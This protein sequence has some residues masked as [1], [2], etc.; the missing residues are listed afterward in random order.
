MRE[1]AA[2]HSR[3]TSREVRLGSSRLQITTRSKPGGRNA[4]VSWKAARMIRFKRFLRTALPTLRVTVIP[5]RVVASLGSIGPS[6]RLRGAVGWECRGTARATTSTKW[7]VEI[8]RPSRPILWNSGLL[9]TRRERPSRMG[10]ILLLVSGHA[11]TPPT[12]ATTILEDFLSTRGA[13]PLAEAVSAKSAGVARLKS[14][15][16]H[17]N[18]RRRASGGREQNSRAESQ[19][20]AAGGPAEGA[21]SQPRLG[22]FVKRAKGDF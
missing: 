18:L 17:R 11:E 5:S 9:R 16:G 7:G 8:L 10:A 13:V 6:L 4:A 19:S 3:T 20:S 22:A 15:L 14:A 21:G 1:A 2:C 12:A